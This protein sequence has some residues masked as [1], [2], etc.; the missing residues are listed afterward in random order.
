[1]SKSLGTGIDPTELIDR[2]GADAMRFGLLAMSSTQ[3]VRFA[4][5]KIAQGQALAN[6]LFNASRFVLLNVGRGRRRGPEPDDRRG[7]LDPQP[8]ARRPRPEI[9]GARR[10][11][12]LLQG[13]VRALRLRLRRAV[14]LVPRAD[15]GPRVRRGAQRPPAAR[16]ARDAAARPPAD[17]VRHRGAVGAPARHR[18]A[19][20]RTRRRAEPGERDAEAEE[21]IGAV[22]EAVT[23]V[24]SWRNDVGV[25]PGR[26]LEARVDGA[27]PDARGQARAPGPRRVPAREPVATAR[28]A[29]EMLTP[30]R[31]RGRARAQARRRARAPRGRD[32]ARR[33]QARQRRASSPRRPPAVVD[34]EREKLAKLREELAGAVTYDEAE[35]LIL[36]LELFGMRFGLERMRRLLT[37]LGLAAGALR[38]ASTSSAPTASPR[39]RG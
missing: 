27:E 28:P 18:R 9:G 1:M 12:R 6:K 29:V 5:E 38:V 20:G 24:R 16:A 39:R 34:A 15:Q 17:P 14:R 36:G 19:A 33:G 31:R 7:P 32:R 11:V 26:R 2:Y 10:R 23:A 37:A 30:R 22:I 13:R 8:A 25:E 35:R 21:A 3:D 4:E